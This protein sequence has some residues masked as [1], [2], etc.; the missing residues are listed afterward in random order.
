MIS[1][2]QLV[3]NVIKVNADAGRSRSLSLRST[4]KVTWVE[5]SLKRLKF[6][7]KLLH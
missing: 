1:F 4:L 2:Y 5:V 3:Q 7:V 6:N